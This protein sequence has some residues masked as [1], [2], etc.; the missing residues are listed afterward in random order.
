M[1]LAAAVIEALACRMPVETPVRNRSRAAERQVLAMTLLSAARRPSRGS[2]GAG[3]AA[4]LAKHD[5]RLAPLLLTAGGW[6]PSLGGGGRLC[7]D[8]T[9]LFAVTGAVTA[10]HRRLLLV[11]IRLSQTSGYDDRNLKAQHTNRHPSPRA[12]LHD[13]LQIAQSEGAGC[14]GSDEAGLVSAPFTA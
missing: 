6:P 5:P 12:D 2:G 8:G 3:D 14:L 4:G 13:K 9:G 1:A 10:S 7:P 11:R